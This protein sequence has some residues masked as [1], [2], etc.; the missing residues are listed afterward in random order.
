[1]ANFL[2]KEMIANLVACLLFFLSVFVVAESGKYPL[3]VHYVGR[4]LVDKNDVQ[5]S[6]TYSWPGIYFEAA[7]TGPEVEIKL[8][9]SNNILA[10]IVD[11]NEPIILTKPGK[12]IHSLK[13]LGDG[14]HRIRL[15][16][17]TETPVGK[18]SFL[19]F[20]VDNKNASLKPE[21]R[22][23]KIEFIGDSMMVGYGNLSPGRECSNDEI[24]RFTNTHQAYGALTAQHFDVDYQINAISGSGVVR[25][26]N[27]GFPDQN[28]T[29]FYPYTFLDDKTL[30]YKEPWSPQIIV[31]GLG[32]NDFATPLNP[33]EK[34]KNREALQDDFRKNYVT[35]ITGLRQ[36]HPQT[37]FILLS[38][39]QLQ[40]QNQQVNKVLSTLT[41]N[42]EKNIHILEIQPKELTGCQWHPSLKDHQSISQS[43][44]DFI[45]AHPQFWKR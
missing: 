36:Q 34:W 3:P 29:K 33:G 42:G 27:G 39:A 18:G 31:L 30:L 41:A 38:L 16:K 26:Y 10:I 19:G 45:N 14:Q 2:R 13:N 12:V 4:V 8:D 15:E 20:Y 21:V 25:N 35:F 40:E 6:Y 23:R 11:D 43:L 9:D 7:F 32:G 28:F 37:T 1:M 5:T 24:F 22:R 17:R 44:I